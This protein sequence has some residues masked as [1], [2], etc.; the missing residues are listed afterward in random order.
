MNFS[1]HDLQLMLPEDVLLGATCAILLIDLFIK[2]SQRSIT[3]WLSLLA[4]VGTLILILVDH[5]ATTIAFGGAYIHDGIAAVLKIFILGV[6]AVVRQ[7]PFTA[8]S[9]QNSFPCGSD[10]TTQEASGPW[11]TSALL[12]PKPSSRAT[13][14]A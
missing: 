3:H 11:P 13:S 4:V 9:T 6:T 1:L 8:L 10:M 7:P 5:D 14:T 12:A 2:P